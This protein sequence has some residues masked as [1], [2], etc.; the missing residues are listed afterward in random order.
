M[1]ILHAVL[2]TFQKKQ[3]C[4]VTETKD[5]KTAKKGDFVFFDG[6]Y[7]SLKPESFESY[8]KEGFS[9]ENHEKLARLFKK[10][11]DKGVYCMLTNH[12][13][14]LINELYKEYNKKTV[15]VKRMINSD[16]SKRTGEEI[17]ITNYPVDA[18]TTST[19]FVWGKF[20]DDE[21][22]S[23][24]IGR[25]TKKRATQFEQLYLL[26]SIRIICVFFRFCV[27][28]SCSFLFSSSISNN[29][30][31]FSKLFKN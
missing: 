26:I 21:R 24:T 27:D 6:P 19:F 13:M 22:C 10:L 11:T 1:D 9:L 4:G 28:N 31:C 5:S 3:L 15:Q 14:E 7:A 8:T 23:E 16:A 25:T 29:F 30:G 2:G 12:N 17:I 18:V 20:R